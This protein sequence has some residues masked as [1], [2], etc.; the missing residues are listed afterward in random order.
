MVP[1]CFKTVQKQSSHQS[2]AS[3]H[4]WTKSRQNGP[5]NQHNLT[6]G[7]LLPWWPY[8]FRGWRWWHG[9]RWQRDQFRH[10]NVIEIYPVLWPQEERKSEREKHARFESVYPPL[11]TNSPKRGNQIKPPSTSHHQKSSPMPHASST[12]PPSKLK[13]IL[14][15]TV[16]ALS[17]PT[18]T[19]HP[20]H[21]VIPPAQDH[22][23]VII[24]YDMIILP[25]HLDD[26]DEI[27]E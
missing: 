16:P 12:I 24:P 15:P 10:V 17:P 27:M 2:I 3:W 11:L 4:F 14:K 23:S 22:K 5:I 8:K 6:V 9:I 20:D 18:L 1:W 7:T 13:L 25:F 21:S 19:S 26:D